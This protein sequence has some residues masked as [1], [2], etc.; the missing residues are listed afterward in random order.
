[1]LTD[2][3]FNGKR[4][5]DVG[6]C[7]T[8]KP[9]YSVALRDLTLSPV[10]GR[11]GDIITDNNRY[12][13]VEVQ[14]KISSVPMFCNYN[15]QEFVYLLSEWLLSEHSYK[16]LR[17]TYNKGYFRKAVV[18]NISTPQIA[19][20]GVVTATITFNCEPFLY[21]DTGTQTF[22]YTGT[23]NASLMIDLFNPE[24][25][26]SA[27]IIKIIGSG[28]YNISVAGQALIT[29]KV[30]GSMTID[31]VN[32]DVYDGNGNS[33]NDRISGLRLPS[34]P[35]GNSYVQIMPVSVVSDYTVEIIPNWRRL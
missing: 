1:M 11:S 18:T 27:P 12:K 22:T 5:S 17:D 13:N 19:I 24:K 7:I 20:P 32:E 16:I 31:K 15:E 10:L 9:H 21:N 34:F 35:P 25:W 33:C 2:F 3:E 14:Y 4:L 23:P 29:A 6:A 28:T 30:D 26:S 8:E